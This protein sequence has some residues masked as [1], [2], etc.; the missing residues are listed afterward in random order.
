MHNTSSILINNTA[1]KDLGRSS[2]ASPTVLLKE[3]G[4][5]EAFHEASFAWNTAGR[6]RGVFGCV[7][8]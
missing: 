3:R 6:L 7:E 4:I 8:R 1:S 5:A 2:P